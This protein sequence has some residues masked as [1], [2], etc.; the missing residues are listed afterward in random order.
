[1]VEHL[2]DSAWVRALDE[3]GPPPTA[4]GFV[5]GTARLW[6]LSERDGWM[7]LYVAD[8]AAPE[9]TPQQLTSGAW[10]ITDAQ[11]TPDGTRFLIV[12]TEAD[13]GERHVYTLPVD[14][15]AAHA[16]DRRARRARD[17]AVAGRRDVGAAVVVR[18]PS[19]RGVPGPRAQ[20][21]RPD[22]RRGAR[23]RDGR[24]GDDE[25]D[26]RSGCRA[27]GSRRGS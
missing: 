21:G 13:A 24:A 26:A 9:A 7:H 15:G 18:H 1:M 10:E 16:A 20:G 19:A 23:S 5:P 22:G 27:R 14:G 11:V 25:P 2:Q 6:F 17:P 12:S 8:L 4:M 3:S